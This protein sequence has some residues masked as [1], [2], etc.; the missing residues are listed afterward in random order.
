MAR[1]I[2]NEKRNDICF[3][4]VINISFNTNVILLPGNRKNLP[5]PLKDISERENRINIQENEKILLTPLPV[6]QFRAGS[7]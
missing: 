1:V 5:E 2:K 7:I 4:K 3:M 6:T